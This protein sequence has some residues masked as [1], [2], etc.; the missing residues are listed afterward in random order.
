MASQGVATKEELELIRDYCI[1]PHMLTMLENDRFNLE[2]AYGIKLKDI[3]YIPIDTMHQWILNDLK[4]AKRLLK[5]ASIKVSDP[6]SSPDGIRCTVWI[7]GYEQSFCFWRELAR[8]E[9]K[10]RFGRYM[11]QIINKHPSH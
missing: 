7:R 8:S 9:I 11:G 6:V 2:N 4:T 5:S 3:L 1:L 10:I